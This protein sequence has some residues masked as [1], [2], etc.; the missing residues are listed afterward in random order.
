MADKLI[1]SLLDGTYKDEEPDE[2]INV[3]IAKI[4]IDSSIANYTG[5]LLDS[6]G[7]KDKIIAVCDENTY[8][9]LGKKFEKVAAKV[10]VLKNGV[11]PCDN[12]VESVRGNSR[13]YTYI[14]AIGSGT[15]N[16]ICKYTS[17][18]G[19][20]DYCVFGTAPSMNGYSSANAAITIDGHKKSLEA[21]LPK[22]IF[23]D[24]DI[25]AN[26]PKRLIQSGLGDSICRST[27]Q[28]DW[29][30]SHYICGTDY[31]ELP[32]KLL[33]EYEPELFA[34]SADLVAGDRELVGLLAKTLIASGLGMYICGGSHP[35]SQGEHM[36]AH[37]MD[38]LNKS[39]D[40]YHGEQIGVTALTMAGIQEKI[41]DNWSA[42][43]FT[44]DTEYEQKILEFFGE[45]IG[46]QC[47]VEYENKL[48]KISSPWGGGN[49]SKQPD[50]QQKITKTI[51]PRNKMELILKNAGCPIAP[52]DLGWDEHFYKKAV[53]HAKY[54][55]SRF[56]FLDMA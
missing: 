19:K 35:A 51:L 39:G 20:Q 43:D 45:K 16:D 31:K 41:L 27:A 34:N 3:P 30:L 55:R 52:S 10:L 15:I 37:T 46:R 4:E 47:L 14:V 29:L 6:I 36:I 38:M 54:S 49:I 21:H 5:D 40:T 56:T 23:L 53:S 48:N 18:L 11:K 7:F 33:A 28:S 25:L 8:E 24:L 9:I 12:I 2:F 17:F 22:G 26:A 13:D 42:L 32:F 50:F 1:D 44:P